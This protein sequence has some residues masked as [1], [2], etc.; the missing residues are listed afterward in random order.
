[1]DPLPS[2]AQAFSLIKQ[3]EK[4]RQRFVS[5]NAFLGSV[6]SDAIT[7][8]TSTPTNTGSSSVSSEAKKQGLKCTYCHK[9]GHTKETCYKLIGYPPRGRG[10]GKFAGNQGGFRTHP[11]QMQSSQQA[12]NAQQVAIA[13]NAVNSPSQLCLEQLQQQMAK[14]SHMV[15]NLTGSS[16]TA[17][18]AT[19]EDHVSIAGLAFS[20]MSYI[21]TDLQNFWIIDSGASSHMCCNITLM[22]DITVLHTPMHVALPNSQSIVVH[23]I[24]SVHLSPSLVIKDVLYIPSFHCNLLSVSRLTQQSSIGI[25]FTS[26]QCL[27]QVQDQLHILA[28][29]V[30]CGGLY[31]FPRAPSSVMQL[32]QIVLFVIPL[33]HIVLFLALLFKLVLNCGIYV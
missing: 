7:T 27:F 15:S 33:F 30:E 9:D 14:I 25:T 20:M 28:T 22:T 23:K 3:E 11:A 18:S 21:P 13:N 29:G 2:I 17:S 12:N 5:S 26:S 16:S 6:K 8:P 24:G 10:K 31:Y 1:M 32:F 4:Q 19:P